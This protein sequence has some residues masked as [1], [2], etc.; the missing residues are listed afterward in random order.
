MLDEA[1]FGL[2]CLSAVFGGLAVLS[3]ALAVR[4]RA[5]SSPPWRVPCRDPRQIARWLLRTPVPARFTRRF[6]RPELANALRRSSLQM[7]S[8]QFIALH[9]V[10]LLTACALLIALLVLRPV[11]PLSGLL[12]ALI[13]VAG[14]C[15]P[16]LWLN[17]Q[18]Q[19]RQTEITLALPDLLDRLAFGLQAG[20]GFEGVLRR[21]AP[22]F[23]GPLG[24]ELRRTI[25]DLDFGWRRHQAMDNLARNTGSLDV[26][27]FV[28]AVRQAEVLGTPLADALRVQ[29]GLL[30]TARRRR[31]QEASRRLPVVILFPLVFLFLPALLIVYLA[32]PLLHLFLMR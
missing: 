21:V 2:Q 11:D 10:A 32:P 19:R 20:L 13:V 3:I 9:W 30:R 18:V 26:R 24:E 16:R 23:P 5:L 28:A 6:D 22:T 15:G 8:H 1:G 25:Q 27:G 31:A 4:T 29:I 17:L 14:A 7:D 12:A